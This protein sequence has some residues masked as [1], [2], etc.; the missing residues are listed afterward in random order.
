MT[1]DQFELI[2][3]ELRT[4]RIL[5]IASI[6]VVCSNSLAKSFINSTFF[7]KLTNA[8]SHSCGDYGSEKKLA[9][10]ENSSDDSFL[11][12]KTH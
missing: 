4:I 11:V 5:I 3:S 7:E 2:K 12:H 9:G 10:D 6:F 1:P 8:S